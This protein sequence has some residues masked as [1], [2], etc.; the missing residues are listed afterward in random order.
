MSDLVPSGPRIDRAA[1]ERIVKRAAELHAQEREI[2]EGLT[3]H[4]LME[5]GQEVGIPT[6]YLQRALMEERTR[7]VA[8]AQGGF[9]VW[10]AGPRSVA[11]ARTIPGT[12]S[13]VE[14]ALQHW[15]T[16]GELLQVKRR[17]PDG[18][19]W[20]RQEGAFASLKRSLG[21]GGRR[22]VLAQASE[23]VSRAVTLDD[24]RVY[25]QLVADLSRSFREYLT[26]SSVIGGGGAVATGV[27]FTL[28]FL[29]P[30]AAVPV[31]LAIPAAFALARS[32]RTDVERCQVALEQV[33][34]RLQHGEIE[35]HRPS[36]PG[37][38]SFVRL[39]DQIKRSLGA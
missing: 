12:R 39:A 33:L 26:G 3:E 19:S 18:T 38:G 35:A 27:A 8:P 17:F 22:Y 21:L 14:T 31:L 20:E 16:Q 11:A 25:V 34:D 4:Q 15:M 29:P 5:L 28:G 6:P 24:S 9:G 37:T 30:F 2:G 13:A 23:V 36:G 10:L 32:R 7:N 1:L